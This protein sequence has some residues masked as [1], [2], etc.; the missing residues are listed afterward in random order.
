MGKSNVKN[1]IVL[2]G[3]YESDSLL[4]ISNKVVKSSS[5]KDY[6]DE[7]GYRQVQHPQQKSMSFAD[8]SV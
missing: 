8:I 5:D 6:I 7:Y 1:E 2:T 4:E 3:D